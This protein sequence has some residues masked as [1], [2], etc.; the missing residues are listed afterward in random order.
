MEVPL[1]SVS[2]RTEDAE[3]DAEPDYEIREQDR[4]LPLANGEFQAP[5]QL[6]P[7]TNF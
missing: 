2:V 1:T 6:R 3:Q 7:D 5:P 4:L